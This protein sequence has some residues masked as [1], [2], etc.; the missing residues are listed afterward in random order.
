[1]TNKEIFRA[2]VF[3]K[4]YR[5]AFGK[6]KLDVLLEGALRGSETVLDYLEKDLTYKPLSLL[7][8]PLHPGLL[9]QLA[10]IVFTVMVSFI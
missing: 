5:K 10:T 9:Q 1:V 7:G 8:I 6:E 4:N 2:L 3:V